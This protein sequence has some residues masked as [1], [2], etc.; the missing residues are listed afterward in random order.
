MGSAQCFLS[1]SIAF[2]SSIVFV[3][4]TST[5]RTPPSKV[6]TFTSQ[7]MAAIAARNHRRLL[8]LSLKCAFWQRIWKFPQLWDTTL[9]N[10]WGLPNRKQDCFTPQDF[11]SFLMWIFHIAAKLERNN[12][13]RGSI[14]PLSSPTEKV[15]FFLQQCRV[16]LVAILMSRCSL[17]EPNMQRPHRIFEASKLTYQ[18]YQL[19]LLN[20]PSPN[21]KF[22]ET[23][24]LIGAGAPSEWTHDF[25]GSVQCRVQVEFIRKL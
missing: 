17:K 10:Y 5:V 12:F 20:P 14:P 6:F 4:T 13:S 19:Q 3:G 23:L 22:A 18:T 11:I 24:V 1:W 7:G 16:G 2:N 15:V 8:C 25:S 21:P 9:H